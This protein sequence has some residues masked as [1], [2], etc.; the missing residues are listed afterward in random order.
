MRTEERISAFIELGTKLEK[1]NG[2]ELEKIVSLARNQNPWFI[3]ENV[4][5][6]ITGISYLLEKDKLQKWTE[7]YNLSREVPKIVGIIMAGNVPLVGFHDLMCVLISGNFAA[8]KTSSQDSVLVNWIV[9]LL[10]DVE[11]RFKKS[12]EVREKLTNIDAVIA[13]G[14]DNT[15]RYFEYYFKSIPH[16][17]RKSRSSIAVLEGSES[18]DDLKNLGKDIFWYFGLGCRNI[19]KILVPENYKPDFFF[20]SIQEFEPIIHHHKYRNN[21]DYNKSIY[22]VNKE[23]HLDNGFL[24]WRKSDDIVSPVSVLY[25]QEYADKAKVDSYLESKKDKIQCI[26]G[27]EFIP[28]GMAQNPEPWDYADE[29]DTLRFLT[30]LK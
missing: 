1:L 28:F 22:L 14:S 20:E 27:K 29:V 10:L 8:I 11:P 5:R 23:P 13:T 12:L 17:I 26:V 25:V 16:I 6:A 7:S 3:E 24:L 4:T 21:Y 30:N 2:E 18:S 15:S 19:S 9:A